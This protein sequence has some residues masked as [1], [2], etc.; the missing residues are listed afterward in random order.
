MPS[1]FTKLYIHHV[2]SVKNRHSLI[3]PDF[4]VELHN[5]LLAIQANGMSDHLHILERLK[6]SL[7]LL[8]SFI[9][10]DKAKL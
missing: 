3:R 10:S 6:R 2:S 9:K 1:S 7:F 5:T 4:E 8:L